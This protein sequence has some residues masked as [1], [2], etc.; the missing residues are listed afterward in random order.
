MVFNRSATP[1]GCFRRLRLATRLCVP[2]VAAL[3]LGGLTPAAS[4]TLDDT[5]RAALRSNP[6]VLIAR[7]DRRIAEQERRQAQ[8]AYYPLLDL[9]GAT[10]IE[11]S[12]TPSLRNQSGT[13]PVLWRNESGI[14]LRQNLFDGFTTDGDVMRGRAR[15]AAAGE[16]VRVSANT[17]ALAAIEA[18]LEVLRNRELV[19]LAQDNVDRHQEIIGRARARAGLNE[20]EPISER[21]TGLGRGDTTELP[22]AEARLLGARAALQQARG[23]LRDAEATFT[24]IVGVR[25]STLSPVAP[26]RADLPRTDEDAFNRA[27]DRSPAIRAANKDIEAAQGE[28][29]QA[30]GRFLPRLDLEVGA[31]RNK[32]IDGVT[33][34]NNDASALLVL[35]YNLYAGGA[36]TA[37]RRAAIER[38]SRA[39]NAVQQ[40]RRNLEQETQ[41]S[42]NALTTALERLPILQD[43]VRQS[44]SA[45][46]NYRTQFEVGRKTVI[47]LLDAEAD[48]AGATSGLV[49]GEL[50]AR[51]GE[52]RLLAATYGL[53]EVLGLADPEV[54]GTE[55]PPASR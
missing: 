12:S 21:T 13:D 47:D 4:Q 35:R 22:R 26:L 49:T 23:R 51:F 50:T 15:E 34:M 31:N 38:I 17:I 3:A 1:S 44:T 6:D 2:L 40:A 41:L 54:E 18:H 53:F 27:M 9:R 48:Y 7:D 24:R 36:D 16:R 45:R 55:R 5:V 19:R 11:Q 32:N 20:N 42:W 8:G 30:D 52:Y 28:L 29:Q 10:G 25:P 46:E 33:G 14:T 43:Q 39:K 37:R